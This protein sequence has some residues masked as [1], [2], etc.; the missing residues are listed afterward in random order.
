MSSTEN[1]LYNINKLKKKD[2]V[3]LLNQYEKKGKLNKLS[4]VELINLFQHILSSQ[5]D[6]SYKNMPK[7]RGDG[8]FDYFKRLFNPYLYNRNSTNVL[9]KYGN[10]KIKY[11]QI[12]RTP[13]YN[14]INKAL[15]LISLGKWSELKTKYSYDD[16]FHLSLVATILTDE[17]K[18]IRILVEKN[19]QIN[20]S[21]NV[22]IYDTT[23]TQLIKPSPSKNLTLNSML[24]KTLERIGKDDF[25]IYSA[26]K[27]NCQHFIKSILISNRLYNVK[28]D[29]FVYQNIVDL[30]D[31]L[32]NYVPTT[33]NAITGLAS[34]VKRLTGAGYV[35]N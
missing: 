25:F 35:S 7:M 12:N 32:P 18:Y 34:W 33:A 20:I 23:E 29:K 10:N 15:D 19:E 9:N 14:S 28:L 4:K 16:M 27:N 30:V 5:A 31:E 21:E 8:I 6:N 2:L 26:F 1:Y 13:I 17:G 11:L 3:N 24:S 22:K